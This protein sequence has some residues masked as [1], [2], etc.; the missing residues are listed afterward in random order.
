MAKSQRSFPGFTKSEACALALGFLLCACGSKTDLVIGGDVEDSAAEVCV[1]GQAPPA[2][3]LVHRY[4]FGDIGTTVSDSI[5]GADG[6]TAAT[7]ADAM[8]GAPGSGAPLDGS[9]Q[10]ALDGTNGYVDLPNGILSSLGDATFMAWTAWRGAAAY[11]RI[12]D[13]G[14]STLGEGK[15]DQCKSC[16]LIMT[17]SGDPRGQGLCAQV[18]TPNLATAEQ[19]VTTLLLDK[20]LRQVALVFKGGV[21]MTLYLDGKAIGSTPITAALSDIVDNNDWLGL[22][23][24]NQDG[25][26]QGSYDEFRI[27]DR[28]LSACEVAV[29]AENG[30]DTL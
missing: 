10:L 7:G 15:R 26:Y 14:T 11:E 23:Q 25:T 8:P 27:Y 20:T 17:A 16:V 24:F 9:G 22:S 13:F 6:Q 2:S 3:S 18:H 29:T 4:S 28:A 30:A 21:S 5:S 19:I 1:S 12:F